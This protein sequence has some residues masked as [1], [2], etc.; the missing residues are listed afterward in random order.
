MPVFVSRGR[1]FIPEPEDNGLIT[2][3]S[4]LAVQGTDYRFKCFRFACEPVTGIQQVCTD[5][6]N[7]ICICHDFHYFLL[8]A[9]H[10]FQGCKGERHLFAGVINCAVADTGGSA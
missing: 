5:M 4:P 3:L 7:R 9:I 2:D 8:S 1:L 10:P 6:C